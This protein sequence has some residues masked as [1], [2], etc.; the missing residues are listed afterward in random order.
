MKTML[1]T[2]STHGKY[3]AMRQSACA[4]CMKVAQDALA[5]FADPASWA[6]DPHGD[7]VCQLDGSPAEYAQKI[8][9]T[10]K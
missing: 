4:E 3:D 1:W 7:W 8:L 2:C 5:V 9:D 10:I 6:V